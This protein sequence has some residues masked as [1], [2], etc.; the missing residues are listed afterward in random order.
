LEVFAAFQTEG[1]RYGEGRRVRI[2]K[3]KAGAEWN[4]LRLRRWRGL[5]AGAGLG[6]AF[7]LS[8]FPEVD[9]R[10]L[11][12]N[13][14]PTF[15]TVAGYRF[16]IGDGWRLGTDLFLAAEFLKRS[17]DEDGAAADD[18]DVWGGYEFG[19]A[20]TF[21]YAP[22]RRKGGGSLATGAEKSR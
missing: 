13:P 5:H 3:A 2:L 16:P 17:Y 12:G 8:D 22:G 20:V 9:G 19:F 4:A 11:R 15:E 18:P 21:E 6:L 1:L 10:T 7:P 14:Y